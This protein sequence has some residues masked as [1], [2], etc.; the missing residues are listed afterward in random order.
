MAQGPTILLDETGVRIPGD[1]RDLAAFR[2]W[3]QSDAFPEKGR[4]DWIGGDVEVDMSPENL[5]A[6]ATPKVALS[7]DL[8]TWVEP[9]DMGVVSSDRTR[10]SCVQADLS[11]EPDVVVLLF[12]SIEA[13]TARLVPGAGGGEGNYIEME[14]AADI[15]VEVVS[16]SSEQKDWERLF[17]R[18][19]LAG[20]REYWICDARKG[21]AT[22]RLHHR[23]PRGYEV[24]PQDADGF[25]RS[26]VLGAA[27][28]FVTLPPRMGIVRYRL[29]TR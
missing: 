19:F 25:A 2:R 26:E 28:R 18:Y 5:N 21:P 12:K 10:L 3:A 7:G 9:R 14:G 6:H 24:T 16:N 20:V 22:L 8:R 27:V 13:G 29:E 23:G 11:A 1:L 15:V 17:E 4:I